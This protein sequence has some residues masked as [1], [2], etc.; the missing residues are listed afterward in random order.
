MRDLCSDYAVIVAALDDIERA[1]LAAPTTVNVV[2][3]S[4]GWDVVNQPADNY[5]VTGTDSELNALT[6]HS[7]IN[8]ALVVLSDTLPD[9]VLYPVSLRDAI[10]RNYVTIA[11]ATIT[12]N[13]AVAAIAG[14]QIA[15]TATTTGIP[16]SWSDIIVE[17]G[18]LRTEFAC[19]D[20]IQQTSSPQGLIDEL[21]PFLQRQGASQALINVI[22]AL[23]VVDVMTQVHY[24]Y[25]GGSRSTLWNNFAIRREQIRDSVEWIDWQGCA[26][27]E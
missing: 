22:Q 19:D 24:E 25:L 23:G 4:Y 11:L 10:E 2:S 16:W 3:N 1:L 20:V 5:E 8:E 26:P 12:Q 7:L 14:Q 15:Q 9:G 13:P 27:E 6:V 17:W 18:S 21:V